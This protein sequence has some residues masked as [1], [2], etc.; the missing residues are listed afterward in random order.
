MP[1]PVVMSVYLNAFSD[2]EL[3]TSLVNHSLAREQGS[4]TP[5]GPNLTPATGKTSAKPGEE[6]VQ[7]V[8][9]LRPA[10]FPGAPRD[11]HPGEQGGRWRVM[12]VTESARH[13]LL[14]HGPLTWASRLGV[15]RTAHSPQRDLL[16]CPD[17]DTE[18]GRGDLILDSALT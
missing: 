5:R 8:P 4:R 18:P 10:P 6:D 2:K 17:K 12:W 3:T 11:R 1:L 9:I 14:S 7:R 16:V 13:P 15:A